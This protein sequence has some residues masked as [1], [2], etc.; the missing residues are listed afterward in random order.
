MLGLFVGALL[1]VLGLSSGVMLTRPGGPLEHVGAALIR[2]A[3][4]EAS[5][6]SD[7]TAATGRI[8]QAL[9]DDVLRRLRTQWYG[10]MPSNATLTDGAV[11]GMVNSLG[12]QF[13]Q[14]VEPKLAKIM[15]QDI[16]GKFEGIGASLRSTKSGAVQIVRVFKN[17]PAEKAG[18]LADDIIESVD[19]R[20]VTGMG[21]TE[22]AALIRGQKGTAVRLTLRR[23]DQPRAFDITITRDEITIPLVTS[24]VLGANNDIAYISL[25][26]FSAPAGEQL[27]QELQALIDKKPKAIIFDLRDNPGGLLSQAASVGDIFLKK[28][29]F[30]IERDFKGAKKTTETTDRGIAQDIPL[31]VLVNGGSASAA[32][33]VAGAIQDTGRGK[34][35]GET[36]FGKGSVQSPQSLSNGGQLRITIERWFTPNDRAIHG[37][38]I[39]PDYTVTDVPGDAD[40]QLDAAVQF[41][42]TGKTPSTD[43]PK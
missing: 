42:D 4:S 19:G 21:T 34:L 15:E 3:D 10:E 33:I 38:G 5:T 25:F 37:I 13:T 9:I 2:P 43:Q 39:A 29:A 36:T 16:S 22:V 18:V 8:D 24:K 40:E 30:V 35:F 12:D 20:L 17:S 1:F 14:Y 6:T 28:G 27:G 23:A 32:E 7:A 26:D 31:I 41:L 11:R